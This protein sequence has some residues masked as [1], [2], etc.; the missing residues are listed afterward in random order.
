VLTATEKLYQVFELEESATPAIGPAG[1]ADYQDL[2]DS[3]YN[4]SYSRATKRLIYFFLAAGFLV[5]LLPWNQTI[6]CEGKVTTMN[7]THR[8]QSVSSR[9]SGRIG[10]VVYQR[11]RLRKK[12]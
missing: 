10:K 4:H 11:G 5:L 9:I 1:A 3:V 8:P 6:S 12:K 7:P 2:Y